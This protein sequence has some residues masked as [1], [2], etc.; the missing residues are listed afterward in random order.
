MGSWW[1]PRRNLTECPHVSTTRKASGARPFTAR[2]VVAST[3]L[4]ARPPVLS[5]R[6][7]VR[8]GALFG[9]SEGTVRVAL[10]RMVALVSWPPTERAATSWSDGS[11]PASASRTR[12]ADGSTR[13]DGWDGGWELHVVR[14]E[15]R[16][17]AE[18]AAL[19]AA[20]GRLRLVERARRHLDAAGQPRRTTSTRRPPTGR[21]R[22]H[23]VHGPA[24]RTRRTGQGA[25]GPR[26]L[27][28]RRRVLV[29]RIR[30]AG[31]E[32]GRRG[33]LGDG[34][35]AAAFVLEA[36]VL[37]HL[38]HDRCCPPSCSPRGGP[39]RPCGPAS[40]SSTPGSWPP[41]VSGCATEVP[42]GGE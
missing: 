27:G 24:R 12:A 21:R 1:L 39:G 8:S 38:H 35:L 17:A 6:V 40:R 3:L 42:R 25:V 20:A 9:I 13:V 18:R 41:G 34:R 2:S 22:R 4:G 10:T 29:E 26:R 16:D 11:A 15:R 33:D 5:A 32:L 31:A 19:R 30:A 37:R 23:V 28:R 14:P 7:L 36:D